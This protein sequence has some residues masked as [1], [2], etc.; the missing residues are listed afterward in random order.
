MVG[1]MF[2]RMRERRA[3]RAREADLEF[4]WPS[5][6][7]RCEEFNLPTEEAVKAFLYHARWQREWETLSIQEI[8][9]I[10]EART[11]ANRGG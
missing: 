10:L 8:R 4:L 9:E 2:A 5:L 3:A 7:A 1:A 11:P 6:L